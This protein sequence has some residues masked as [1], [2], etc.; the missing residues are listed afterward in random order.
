MEAMVPSEKNR[1]LTLLAVLPPVVML[2]LVILLGAIED[3]GGKPSG[4]V[5]QHIWQHRYGYLIGVA[6]ISTGGAFA[7]YVYTAFARRRA[8]TYFLNHMHTRFWTRRGERDPDYRISLFV[9]AAVGET[10]RCYYRTDLRASGRKWSQKQPG[11]GRSADGVVGA[12]WLTGMTIQVSS[13]PER[14]TED[15]MADYRMKCHITEAIQDR[16]SWPCAALLGVPV[17]SSHDGSP[18]AV[19]LI[20]RNQPDSG[21]GNVTMRDYEHDVHVCTMILQGQL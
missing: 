7:V 13:P 10:L 6:S 9:P 20:E 18:I 17:Q 2:L 4:D 5:W 14:P 12:V 11:D 8:I 16:R 21:V 3:S 15:E 1:L 19:L